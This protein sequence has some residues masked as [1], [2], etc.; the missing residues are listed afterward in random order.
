MENFSILKFDTPE[1]DKKM[2]KRY[3]RDRGNSERIDALITECISLSR[4]SF[5]CRVCSAEFPA[6]TSGATVRFGDITVT[7]ESLAKHLEGCDRAVIFGATV[8][9]GIDR[10]IMKHSSESALKALCLDA[11][12]SDMIERV[13]DLFNERVNAEYQSTRS[14]FS[15]GY[16]DL[17]IDFQRD[18]F[19]ALNLTRNLGVYLTEGMQMTPS[20]SVTAIIGAKK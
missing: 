8:G 17:P 4:D 3:L 6:E 9:I 19:A 13:C 5:D 15:P 2:I 14:R 12:G 18:I 1:P 16:G 20:K 11:A 7:S 10:L